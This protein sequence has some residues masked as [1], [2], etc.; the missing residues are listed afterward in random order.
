MKIT[1]V[2]HDDFPNIYYS[3]RMMQ[4]PRFTTAPGSTDLLFTHEKQT[5]AAH[6]LVPSAGDKAKSA[7]HSAGTAAADRAEREG[8]AHLAAQQLQAT[9]ADNGKPVAIKVGFS[10]RDYCVTIGSLCTVAQL[11]LLISTITEVAVPDM[12]LIVKG[13]VLKNNNQLI[14]DTKIT[15]NSKVVVMSS[16]AHTV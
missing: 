13:T 10:N 3:V 12:K 6:L 5:D 14:K 2:H 15:H 1:G 11:K 7:K 4:P 9:L 8:A 16:N